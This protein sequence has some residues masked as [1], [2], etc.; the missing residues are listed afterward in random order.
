MKLRL[1]C[2]D[3]T[4]VVFPRLEGSARAREVTAKK[5][6]RALARL[7]QR[8]VE[9]L[10]S[11]EELLK[12]Y[13]AEL[14]KLLEREQSR[15]QSV[16]SRLTGII[17]L[18]SIAATIVLGGLVSLAA[19]TL[20][21]PAGPVAWIFA[22]GSLYLVLQLFVALFAAVNGLSRAVHL[23]DTASDL[24]EAQPLAP[25]V[26][27]RRQIAR[28]L[29]HLRDYRRN[30]DAKVDHMAVAHRATKNFLVGLLLL[31]FAAALVAVTRD[32]TTASKIDYRAPALP[33]ASAADSLR[34]G[35]SE[36][37]PRYTP[38]EPVAEVI[39]LPL[40]MTTGGLALLVAGVL[41]V[42]AGK[43][44]RNF[45]LGAA[46]LAS[47][48]TLS[49]LG[50]SKFEGQL[51]KFDKLIGELQIHLFEQAPSLPPPRVALLRIATIGPFPDGDH[52]LHRESVLR[53]LRDRLTSDL[54]S[55]ISGWQ[56]VGRADKRQ[57][58]ADRALIYGSNQSLAMSRANWVR[59]QV[60]T[61][62]P[63]FN[64]TTSVISVGGA[65][66]VGINVGPPEL[67][68]DRMVDV[69]ALVVQAVDKGGKVIEKPAQMLNCPT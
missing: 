19:G 33:G 6:W 46:L 53:C 30:G 42:G 11:N 10:G 22:V 35:V 60:L 39:M 23:G 45:G 12:Q 51:G 61:Q 32:A 62:I 25:P 58:K 52:V 26:R 47:G 24:F 38:A 20:P 27:L 43:P 2:A 54:T 69:Y 40:L 68:S 15:K 65:G 5:R 44:I 3:L 31:A 49:L 29:D 14:D 18:T 1:R 21:A 37:P 64:A 36:V 9:Q 8:S 41:F 56:I 57:L 4:D 63:G 66:R 48:T 50:G 17:G 7:D 28:K 59:D 55:T 13:T 34:K 16:E 67:Q